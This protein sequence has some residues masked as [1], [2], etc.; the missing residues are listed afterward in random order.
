MPQVKV[1][2]GA[3][4]NSTKKT[5]PPE[6]KAPV[7]TGA[8][9]KVNP[10]LKN[11]AAKKAPTSA[12][13][14]AAP[15]EEP[16]P[17]APAPAPVAPKE[18][19][20]PAPQQVK[21][22]VGGNKEVKVQVAAPKEVAAPKKPAGKPPKFVEPL[23]SKFEVDEGKTLIIDCVCEGSPEPDVDW[24]FQGKIVKDEGRYKYFFEKGNVIGLEVA[25]A[26]PADAGEY[27]C[28]C[29]NDSGKEESKTTVS[30][31]AKPAPEP[32]KEPTP[33]PSPE[34][35]PEPVRKVEPKKPAS[36]KPAPTSETLK[37]NTFTPK[38]KDKKK[39]LPIERDG[40]KPENPEKYYDFGDEIGR[41]KFAVVKYATSKSTGQKY[42][43]KIIKFDSDS[44]K[45]AIREYDMMAGKL[46]GKGLVKLHEAYLVRKYL[47]L[48]MEL[49]DGKTL[50]D[51]VA[52]MHAIT[53][54][55]VA[56]FIRQLL[57]TLQ[58]MHSK[59]LVHLDLRPT[60]IRFVS[61]RDLVILDYNSCR[62]LANKKAGAVVDVIG[63]TE[64]CAPEMLNFDPVSPWSDVW[65]IGVLAYIL[66]TGISPFFY[67]DEDKVVL[68]VQKVKYEFCPEFDDVS[69]NAKD[70][71]KKIFKRAPESRLSAADALSHEWLSKDYEAQRKR[72]VLRIQDV[73]RETD[74][75]LY[76]EEEEE[77]VW[78]SLV[79]RTFDEEEYDSP[80]ESDDEEEEE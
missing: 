33:E 61:G 10:F 60:N 2:F 24:Y 7:S 40:I 43:A 20:K 11:D 68:C 46:E 5:F 71:I 69:A 72:N 22:S 26:T 14:P 35:S 49:V 41:G 16:K 38:R 78:A 58:D 8:K 36:T 19:P 56:T 34:P 13:A 6:K 79:F 32:A 3:K 30:V 21:V 27:K 15:K 76:S 54:D 75:R 66:L 57:E 1:N 63:D 18:E 39:K 52:S 70:F 31:K 17:A 37:A 42:A 73:L 29:F 67:E 25:K 65:S 12:P 77:Y 59:N 28:V 45:F 64:F 74:E 48:I 62:H 23:D 44:L 47:I 53:E 9:G 55:D 4:L 50:L 51:K 80:E